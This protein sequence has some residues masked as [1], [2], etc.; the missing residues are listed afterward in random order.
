MKKNITFLVIFLFSIFIFVL[1]YI[2]LQKP[3]TYIPNE[4][5]NKK[6]IEFSS[7]D[8]FSGLELN[9]SEVISKNKFTIINIWASWCL[10]CRSEHKYL[11][12]LKNNSN[13]SLIGLNYKDKSS[14]AKKFINDFG[15]PFESIL[16]DS[17]GIISIEIGAY[18]IPETFIIN[19]DK[20]I[21][22]KYVGPLT[23]KNIREIKQIVN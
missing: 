19:S 11:M 22:K 18:G 2:G 10:P 8:L 16:I 21:I 17:N 5:N 4:L 12:S 1:F 20:E 13:V 23:E 15:N 6:I 7:K 14:N 3:N 9:S